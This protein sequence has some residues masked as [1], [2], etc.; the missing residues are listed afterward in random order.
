MTGNNPEPEGGN[1]G[2][3]GS[4]AAKKPQG[5][6]KRQGE[7]NPGASLQQ[8]LRNHA[9]ETGDDVSLALTSYINKRF[10]YRLSISAYRDRFI[11]QLQGFLEYKA[12]SARIAF[13]S[14]SAPYTS[15]T[16]SRCRHCDRANRKSQSEFFCNRCCFQANADYNASVNIARR[17]QKTQGRIV[18]APESWDKSHSS[19]Y[20]ESAHLYTCVTYNLT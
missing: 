4:P 11:L 5:E 19:R 14:I 7:R 1:A 6:K 17:G 20:C 18:S 15:Q 3:P 2:Q 9:K 13:L 16:C 8:K 10:L 12:R